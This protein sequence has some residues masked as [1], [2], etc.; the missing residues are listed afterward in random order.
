MITMDELSALAHA[1]TEADRAVD[2]AEQELKQR[3][4]FA[5][6][7][8]EETLPG[9]MQEL[10]LTNITLGSGEKIGIK[11]EVYL[12]LSAERKEEAFN[13]LEQNNFGG[14]IKTV[15]SVQ[16]GKGELEVAQHTAEELQEAGLS[17]ELKRDVHAQTLKA[18]A[19]EQLSE[20]KSFPMDLFGAR[21]VWTATVKKP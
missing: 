17:P 1:L 2:A 9:A 4:E 20:G 18:W 12:A 11:Q 3:K 13:W 7:L 5:R 19:R 8:R 16:F 21:P 14:L 15:V 10:Q 6:I